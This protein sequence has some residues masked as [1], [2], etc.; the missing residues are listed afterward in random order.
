MGRAHP[1]NDVDVSCRDI[2]AAG[3]GAV[4]TMTAVRQSVPGAAVLHASFR[5]VRLD[6]ATSGKPGTGIAIL[7]V[8]AHPFI[9]PVEKYVGRDFADR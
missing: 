9:A 7:S 2:T 5:K 3:S 8:P 4:P 1:I 6:A